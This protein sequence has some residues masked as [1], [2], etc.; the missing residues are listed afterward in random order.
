MSLISELSDAWI[1]AKEAERVAVERRREIEDK[2]AEI[3]GISTDLD[4]T[5][6]IDAGDYRIKI[7]GRINRTVDSDL[8]Q[9]IA[10]ENGISDYLS[11]L[12]RWKAELNMKAW[13]NTSTEVTG[14]LSLA[15]TSKPGR[16]SFSITKT[17]EK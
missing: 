17:E 11:T 10:A 8:L 6:N 16:P 12:F 13:D 14:K 5:K 4:G 2:I 1:Q 9:E 15:I 3:A 7:V